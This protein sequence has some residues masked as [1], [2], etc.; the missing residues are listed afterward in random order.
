MNKN[1]FKWLVVGGLFIVPFIPFFV[2]S[3]FFFPYITSKAFVWR[4]L[5]EIVFA[6]W[7]VLAAI[8]PEY[9]PKRSL[10]LYS[11][12]GFLII[13]GAADI[14]G[15]APIKSFWSN[16]E[17]MEGFISLLHLGAF[18]LIIGSVFDENLWKKWWNTNLIASVIMIIYCLFQ[19]SG[20]I[21]IHQGGGR[22]DGT[23]GNAAYLAI[24]MLINIF[25]SLLLYIK[26]RGSSI[27]WVYI[28]LLVGQ[29]IILY[30][31]ATR[32]AI[33]G[34][35]GGL[36]LTALLN[37]RNH[38]EPRVRKLSI[39]FLVALVV[40]L[41]TFFAIKNTEFVRTSPVLGR[42]AS[43]SIKEIKTEGRSFV[44][45]IAIEGIKEKPIFGWGQENFN[46][47][48]NEHYKPQM[49]KIE[50]WFDRAHNI[51][52]DWAI[53]G[54]VLGILAYLGLYGILIYSL[55][56]KDQTLTYGEKTLFVGL[57]SAYFFHNIFV[58]DHLLSYILF[59]AIL[60]YIHGQT[61]SKDIYSKE[62][63]T[64]RINN[65]LIPATAVLLILTL[66]FVNVKP[67]RTNLNLIQALQIVQG[68]G[69]DKSGA[70]PA[71]Q[72][73]YA[74]SSL[75]RPEVT[76]WIGTS[77]G[78]IINSNI[79]QEEKQKYIDFAK[80]AVGKQA[81]DYSQDARYQ[82]L[83]G[84]LFAQV[85]DTQNAAKYLE[86]AEK[87]I[88][89]KQ[90]VYYQEGTLLINA[91]NAKDALT[92]FKKAY[93]LATENEEA[94]VMYLVGAIYAKDESLMRE[95]IAKLSPER[96][97]QND[98]V[99]RALYTT[100]RFTDLAA[101]LEARLSINDKDPQNYINLS[102]AYLKIGR[103]NEAIALLNKLK[104][105]A[106]SYAKDVDNYIQAI[107][108]GKI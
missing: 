35:L 11:L 59:V 86:R 17:R 55:W 14:L 103:K 63:S 7:L 80:Y 37:I 70:L 66:Y 74:M 43:I 85:G 23:F 29:V 15:Q 42:F 5:I 106:P 94:G 92:V 84:D 12:L 87:L 4:I 83:A 31:T 97:L 108:E 81:D 104:E 22:I 48:F 24:Y 71:F 99:V 49:Y 44:W 73:A 21:E 52:L 9:R 88:P 101:L 50:P 1:I 93:E 32:G 33:L 27:K 6:A 40:L 57:L 75:G 62:I 91:G 19:L 36:L 18:F 2:S 67:M 107:N 38:E 61:V 64:S 72:K 13:I 105:I 39:G 3:S 89:G 79:S 78:A 90:Q 100:E 30:Y 54:G 47:V 45:P 77:A 25:I 60:A 102:I 76:E 82:L 8:V 96:I 65:I 95:L 26:S 53:A 58:F 46:Y 20:A 16:F 34:L 98:A 69:Q 51:F 10:I 68:S 41:G 56:K 28:T